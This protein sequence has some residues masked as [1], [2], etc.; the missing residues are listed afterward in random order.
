MLMMT[1]PGPP[2]HPSAHSLLAT[3][4]RV[5]KRARWT[6]EVLSRE[7]EGQKLGTLLEHSWT[8]G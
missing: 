5:S 4:S 7:L 2:L 3:E 8:A 6:I 1:L